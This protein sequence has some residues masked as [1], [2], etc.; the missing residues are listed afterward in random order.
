[1]MKVASRALIAGA[2]L[3]L[4][5]S[6]AGAAACE[7][8]DFA[9][10]VDGAGAQ[11]R[12]FNL[13]A[14][15]ALQ[16][17]IT[18]LA[19]RKGWNARER[20]VKARQ[21]LADDKT[22]RLDATGNEL[23]AKLDTLGRPDPEKPAD[24]AGLDELKTAG[25]ELL[26]VMKAKSAHAIGMIDAEIAKAPKAPVQAAA[27]ASSTKRTETAERPDSA[28]KP[29]RGDKSASKEGSTSSWN[30]TAEFDPS[31]EPEAAAKR[32][33]PEPLPWKTELSAEEGYTIEEI[34]DATRGFF[35]TISTNLASVLEYAFE[36]S[37]RPTA[38]VL[39]TE[40]GAAFLAGLRYGS[41]TLY[42][43]RGAAREVYWH[44]PS[45]GYDL[46]AEGS[47]TLFLIYSLRDSDALYRR[48][49]GIDGSAYLV[50]GVG[51]TFLKGGDVIMAPIRSGIGLRLGANIG[52]VRFT[53]EP[54]W[55]PF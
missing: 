11:L 52:Y 37:G 13:E 7:P 9:K 41:G 36:T 22:A 39:G 28:P 42:P 34:R 4:F 45:L 49:T 15:P 43:R 20:E 31:Y 12:A 50:G 53:P 54:S 24:C 8:E 10:A 38:Y 23:L 55:N 29:E 25:V 19:E 6:G 16:A 48:F 44:G 51:I 40:G 33:T 27:P 46:G 30:T 35:G 47:R 32:P 2:L 3:G 17:K 5:T 21:L 14:T 26:A 1:M 18:E